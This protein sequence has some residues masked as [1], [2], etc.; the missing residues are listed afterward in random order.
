MTQW[1]R[2]SLIANS[3][4][5]SVVLAVVGAGTAVETA[6][7]SVLD[8]VS[9]YSSESVQLAQV[10][11]VSELS[12]V[13]PTDWAYTA[14]QR[15]VEEYRCIE[16]YPNRTFQ[17]N[18]AM[19]RYEFAAGLNA[20]LDTIVQ[21]IGGGDVDTNDLATI[22]RLQEQFQAEL[23]TLRGRVDALEADVA[24]LEA[25][26]FSTTTK[27]RGEVNA[28]VVVPFD[29]FEDVEDA[30]IFNARAR[31]N[32][33]T[34]FTGEDRLRIR[35]QTGTGAAGLGSEALG[36]QG[37]GFEDAASNNSN[38]FRVDDF[39]YQFP[40]GD[41]IEVIVAANSIRGDNF[42]TSTIVPFDGPGVLDAN[43]PNIY[44]FDMGGSAGAGISISLTD[45]L[46]FDAGYSYDEEEGSNPQIGAFA[47]NEQ[48]YIG[49][50]SFLSD[51]LLDL[52]FVFMRGNDG[53]DDNGVGG[54][55]GVQSFTN[56]FGGLASLDFGRFILAGYFAYHES[57]EDLGAGF[58]DDTIS[59]Q[60]GVAL[61]DLFLE[62]DLLGIYGGLAPTYVDDA[63]PI[64]I[65][66]FYEVPVSDYLTITPAVIY[67]DGDG[68]T[69]ADD[70]EGLFGAVRATFTF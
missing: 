61:P 9:G 34:S 45:S 38:Q 43:E 30:T 52:A 44:E 59:F 4:A 18:R 21:L 46:F 29:D 1:I 68:V 36:F 32:F 51:G 16:G 20:C 37:T 62:G 39:F 12:D 2:T 15:L 42:V 55:V 53:D 26:Q 54:A 27:L 19:T 56:T 57:E 22:R 25:N 14:L 11:S 65:E 58:D 66:G 13:R 64:Y 31:L 63:D 28:N 35:F 60:A 67:L 7:A 49:Q 47:A 33:D 70:Q 23:A 17:G 48:S 69:D 40:V 3:T 5:A 8:Q 6:N 50:L 24:E 10:T 41:R